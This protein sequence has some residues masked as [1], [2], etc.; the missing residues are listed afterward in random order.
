VAPP[1]D[2][3]VVLSRLQFAITPSHV[4]CPVLSVGLRCF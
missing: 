2:C 3:L 4:L 1:A